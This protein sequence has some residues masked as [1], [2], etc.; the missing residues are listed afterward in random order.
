MGGSSA[1]RLS[2]LTGGSTTLGAVGG[3]QTPTGPNDQ[4]AVALNPQ[5]ATWPRST[6]PI[7]AA[8][9]GRPWFSIMSSASEG[10]G[11][12]SRL[13]PAPPCCLEER[14][15]R[16]S[17]AVSAICHTSPERPLYARGIE[18]LAGAKSGLGTGCAACLALALVWDLPRHLVGVSNVHKSSEPAAAFWLPIWISSIR[19]NGGCRSIAMPC[20][21]SCDRANGGEG[22]IRQTRLPAPLALGA[23]L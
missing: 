11:G 13:S 23:C 20:R 12:R 7:W 4:Q 22:C 6:T 18:G 14:L 19:G 17:V 10:K 3:A 21:H 5:R 16:R 15:G 2:L 8:Q 1:S 9:S